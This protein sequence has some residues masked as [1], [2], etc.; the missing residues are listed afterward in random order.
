MTDCAV[1]AILAV[2]SA[3]EERVQ[4]LLP[5]PSPCV[6]RCGIDE[7][8]H[9]SGCYRSGLEVASWRDLTDDEKWDLLEQLARRP[10]RSQRR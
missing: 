10:K 4:L 2:S 5:C 3:E 9:C 6:L 1:P 7:S 8:L